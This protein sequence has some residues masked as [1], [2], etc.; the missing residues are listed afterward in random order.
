MNLR[1]VRSTGIIFLIPTYLFISCLAVTFT[2]GSFKAFTSGWQP[3]PIVAPPPIPSATR[4]AS[5]ALLLHA[6]ANG[7]TALTG[8]EAVSNGVPIFRSPRVVN[9]TRSL[10]TIVVVL[11]LLLAGEA[12]L[13]NA[14]HIAATE[15]G[16]A[17][18][19][20]VL[21]M[22]LGAVTGRGGFYDVAM[23][24]IVTVLILSANTS[25]ADFPRLCRI[26]AGDRFLPEPFVHRG[27][28][29][30]FSYGVLLLSFLA[31]ILLVIFGGITDALIPL[32]AVGA[33]SAFTMSQLGMV[34]HW[35]KSTAPRA[36]RSM[37]LNAL[38]ALTT[39]MTLLVVM[40]AKF[41]EGA[42]ITIPL[43][44]GMVILLLK[45]RSHYDRIAECTRTELSLAV[46]PLNAPL[47][48]VPLRRWDATSLKALR[49]S[50]TLSRD[51]VV[52]Q[53]LTQ[54]RELEDHTHRSVAVH[55]TCTARNR[56]HTR[57]P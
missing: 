27:R 28:R 45:I 7:C 6:F 3:Q 35:R 49:L 26:L 23:G 47:V 13:C 56:Y 50:M 18:Y 1:G 2:I 12:V 48:V 33:L 40:S 16:K 43:A 11:A 51:V 30:A 17:G 36:R 39:L 21:S 22:L 4:T 10:T 41:V 54:D 53:V 20:S 46:G 57:S 42:W 8:V 29:L 24:S 52:V 55:S 38:G 9:A 32:F 25:F 5:I 37:I 15:P 44:A 34:A 19:Q 14:Y 31:G